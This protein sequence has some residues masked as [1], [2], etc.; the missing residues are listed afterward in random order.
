MSHIMDMTEKMIKDNKLKAE[1]SLRVIRVK[2]W[3]DICGNEKTR[4]SKNFL[5]GHSTKYPVISVMDIIWTWKKFQTDKS[6]IKTFYK[7]RFI[8]RNGNKN[9]PASNNVISSASIHSLI[10]KRPKNCRRNDLRW[11]HQRTKR[12]GRVLANT[13]Y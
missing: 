7:S 6:A 10:T 12:K 8:I 3:T 11:G 5:T 13:I 1:R 4:H 2:N 9:F